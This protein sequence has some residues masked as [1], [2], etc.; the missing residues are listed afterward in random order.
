LTPAELRQPRADHYPTASA[1][2][3]CTEYAAHSPRDRLC[4]SQADPYARTLPDFD[5]DVVS[6][7]GDN[8]M[9]RPA[10]TSTREC[11]LWPARQGL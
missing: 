7:A 4:P 9:N 11:D 10:Q 5:V 3:S 8:S 1:A 2:G 6:H